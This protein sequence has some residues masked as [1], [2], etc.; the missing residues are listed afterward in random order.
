MI[1][2][3][4]R[5]SAPEAVNAIIKCQ[6]FRRGAGHYTLRISKFGAGVFVKGPVPKISKERA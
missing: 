4:S 3:A 6:E 1:P 2:F 5:I